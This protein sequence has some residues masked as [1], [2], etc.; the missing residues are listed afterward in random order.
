MKDFVKVDIDGLTYE[1]KCELSRRQI[2]RT[3][4]R[5]HTK[6]FEWN[7]LST[8]REFT[9]EEIY[10]FKAFIK[11]PLLFRY[12]PFNE[13]IA[14]SEFGDYL[15]WV[16]I[17]SN[18]TL[19]SSQYRKYHNRVVE[20]IDFI[21][22]DVLS[23]AILSSESAETIL[24]YKDQLN[25]DYFVDSSYL[26]DTVIDGVKDKDIWDK[27]DY[28]RRWN[29]QFIYKYHRYFNWK[30]IFNEYS[31]LLSNEI[32]LIAISDDIEI[33]PLITTFVD[34]ISNELL[35]EFIPFISNLSIEYIPHTKKRYLSLEVAQELVDYI[36]HYNTENHPMV[37]YMRKELAKNIL[38]ELLVYN[39]RL[40]KDFIPLFDRLIEIGV[41]EN[42]PEGIYRYIHNPMPNRDIVR[43]I[44]DK[45]GYNI[46]EKYEKDAITINDIVI[47]M[48]VIPD[49]IFSN[50]FVNNIDEFIAVFTEFGTEKQKSAI[51]EFLENGMEK[52]VS[53]KKLIQESIDIINGIEPTKPNIDIEVES[54]T[55]E[56]TTDIVDGEE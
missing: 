56:E 6:V 21:D 45:V 42:F 4:L 36:D 20:L 29:T 14:D 33:H 44:N 25:F 12:T 47:L 13:S 10:E 26:P 40:N 22:V 55:D 17:L 7:L 48:D 3:S 49:L 41:E 34:N 37:N 51:I 24:L 9:L 52:Y 1:E 31:E 35:K 16:Y 19:T 27:I 53:D 54:E 43:Y 38:Q 28:R 15:D 30:L 50:S 23:K 32:F 2:A 8:Y 46:Y 39:I 11:F 18:I 5:E